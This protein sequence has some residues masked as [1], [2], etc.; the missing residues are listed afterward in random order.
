[1]TALFP[2]G[3][4]ILSDC[5]RYRYRLE[6]PGPGPTI[7][8]IMLNPSTADADVDDQTIRKCRGFSERWGYGRLVVVNLFAWRATK[9]R[10]LRVASDPVGS[11]NDSHIGAAVIDADLVVC[12]W[13]NEKPSLVSSRAFYVARKLLAGVDL[14][15]IGTTKHGCPLHPC[16]AGYTTSPQAWTMEAR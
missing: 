7:V 16:M 1:M 13:G 3:S 8:W 2:K 9:P 15:V 6:R 4:A 14:H 12:A 10:E 11:E 5:Q